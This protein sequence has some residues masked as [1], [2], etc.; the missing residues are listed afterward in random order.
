MYNVYVYAFK[1]EF[2]IHVG[3]WELDLPGIFVLFFVRN[4]YDK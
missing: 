4:V 1:H 2:K 3:V